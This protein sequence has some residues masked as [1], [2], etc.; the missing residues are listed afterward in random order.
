[1]LSTKTRLEQLKDLF[2]EAEDL[3]K[4][5][6]PEEAA[7]DNIKLLLNK[8]GV[9]PVPKKEEDRVACANDDEYM[10]R[11]FKVIGGNRTPLILQNPDLES[12]AS[13]DYDR[14]Q[15]EKMNLFFIVPSVIRPESPIKKSSMPYILFYTHDKKLF[16]Y[17]YDGEAFSDIEFEGEVP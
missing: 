7:K 11:L 2:R 15:A 14:K 3:A 16:M 1:M 6:T 4:E 17:P 12:E 5:L 8:S 13:I 9:Q 10:A